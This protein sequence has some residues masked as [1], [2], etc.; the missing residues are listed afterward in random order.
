MPVFLGSDVSASGKAADV[1]VDVGAALFLCALAVLSVYFGGSVWLLRFECTWVC[2]DLRMLL[3]DL[4]V[5]DF[6]KLV[7]FRKWKFL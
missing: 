4:C 6:S 1:S 2:V 7:C 5:F 3:V